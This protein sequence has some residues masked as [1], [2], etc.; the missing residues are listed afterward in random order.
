[1]KCEEKTKFT[2]ELEINKIKEKSEVKLYHYKCNE[3]GFYHLTR[4]NEQ[5]KKDIAKKHMKQRVEKLGFLYE[6]E[7]NK[8]NKRVNNYGN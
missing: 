1:M 4:W 2:S 5:K 6:N 8:R 7:F 3:C